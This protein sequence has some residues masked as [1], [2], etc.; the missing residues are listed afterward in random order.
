MNV[1]TFKEILGFHESRGNYLI[2]NAYGFRGK[3]QFGRYMID[4]FAGGVK[5]QVFLHDSV[6]Q[7]QAMTKAIDYYIKYIYKYG[8]DKYVN[9][10]IDGVVITMES[11]MLGCHFSPL[12]LK[13]FLES[14]G[15][16][17]QRDANITIRD[18]MKKFE[19]KGLKTFKYRFRCS[20]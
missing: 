11:L 8:Y 13:N 1:Y 16:I 10:E 9:K 20:S 5:G 6:L 19:N 14:D 12:Y 15:D 2:T 4:R 18:Y 17:N 7:E 3:Y